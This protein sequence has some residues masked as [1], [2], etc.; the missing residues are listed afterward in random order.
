M[1]HTQSIIQPTSANLG[2][3][4]GKAVTAA[5]EANEAAQTS[6]EAAQAAEN[7]AQTVSAQLGNIGFAIDPDDGGL[8]IIIYEE[9]NE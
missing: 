2:T 4:V 7:T 5:Q 6:S 1:K 8:N 3:A 9:E